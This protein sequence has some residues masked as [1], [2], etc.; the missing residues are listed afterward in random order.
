[1]RK[2]AAR[3]SQKSDKIRGTTGAATQGNL[4]ITYQS[5]SAPSRKGGL[6]TKKGGGRKEKKKSKENRIEKI[7]RREQACSSL[8]REIPPGRVRE[9]DEK[10]MALTGKRGG[11]EGDRKVVTTDSLISKEKCFTTLVE[12]DYT[13]KKA[14]SHRQEKERVKK[15]RD[16]ETDANLFLM[17]I[18]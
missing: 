4:A 9:E 2:P 5:I 18:Q 14:L 11:R 3:G 8:N 10:K 6:R 13:L 7:H 12:Q 15:E 16:G 1:M 17:G